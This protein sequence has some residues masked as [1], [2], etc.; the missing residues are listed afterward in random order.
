MNDYG[1]FVLVT[2]NVQPLKFRD[3]LNGNNY[4]LY[5]KRPL[6]SNIHLSKELLLQLQHACL[7]RTEIWYTNQSYVETF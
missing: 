6:Y 7:I 2:L 5:K 1:R 4:L 3:T